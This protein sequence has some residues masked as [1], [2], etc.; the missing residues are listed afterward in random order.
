MKIYQCQLQVLC[1]LEN[2]ERGP[3]TTIVSAPTFLL[4]ASDGDDARKR[5]ILVVTSVHVFGAPITIKTSGTVMAVDASDVQ[6][7]RDV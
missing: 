4:Q 7:W 5:A 1:T 6:E 2:P 3:Q